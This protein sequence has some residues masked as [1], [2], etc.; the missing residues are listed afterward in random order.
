MA[1]RGLSVSCTLLRELSGN[2]ATILLVTDQLPPYPLPAILGPTASGKTALALAL[3]ER[4]ALEVVSVDSALVYRGMDIGTAKPTSEERARCPHHLIDLIEPE[5]VYTAG[6][7]VRDAENAAAAITARGRLPLFVGGTMLYA[8]AFHEGLASLPPADPAL[9]ARIDARAA[10]EGWPQLH[11][12]LASLDPATAARLSPNDRQRIQR[13]LEVVLTTGVPL[14]ETLAR[15]KTAAQS[16]RLAVLA[17]IP[18]DRTWLHQRIAD[19]FYQ[20]L[21]HGFLEEV[22]RLRTRPTLTADHPAIRA[23][24][25]RQAWDYLEGEIS[26]DEMVTRAIAATRQLAKRQLTWLRQFARNWR[27]VTILD[28]TGP[29]W[30]ERATEWLSRQAITATIR[31]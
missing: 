6:R 23:V 22:E 26:Y 29:H 14:A 27:Q 15:Q 13:A 9:R 21:T 11:A 4:F 18:S 31:R 24:G 30:I 2:S 7:F 10:E 12:W 28:P 1:S 16:D 25:Y 3:S 5:E 20:M 19:R 8:K 17:L